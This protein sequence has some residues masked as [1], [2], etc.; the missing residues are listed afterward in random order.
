MSDLHV[1]PALSVRLVI[2]LALASGLLAVV[3]EA[4]PLRHVIELVAI[5]VC[6]SLLLLVAILYGISWFKGR[7]TISRPW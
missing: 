3:G 6:Y 1:Q 5:G 7:G 4:V 2:A